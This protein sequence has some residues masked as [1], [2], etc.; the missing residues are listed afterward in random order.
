MSFQNLVNKQ[1]MEVIPKIK[2]ETNRNN[3][4]DRSQEDF[5]YTFLKNQDHYES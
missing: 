3:G 1:K 2:R 5:E 4:S